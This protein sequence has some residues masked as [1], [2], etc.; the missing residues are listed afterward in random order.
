MIEYYEHIKR[1]Q[2]RSVSLK[3]LKFRDRDIE[4]PELSQVGKKESRKKKKKKKNS[5]ENMLNF[6]YV[7]HE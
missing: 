5:A 1:L 3:H 2:H 4:F 7:I 6:I